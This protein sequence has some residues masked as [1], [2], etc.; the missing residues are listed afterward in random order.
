MPYLLGLTLVMCALLACPQRAASDDGR[1]TSA[2]GISSGVS[3]R[4]RQQWD[5]NAYEPSSEWSGPNYTLEGDG[6]G[7]GRRGREYRNKLIAAGVLTG[8]GGTFIA[9]GAI[10]VRNHSADPEPYSF[11]PIAGYTF[12]AVGSI[13]TLGGVIWM[14]VAGTELRTYKHKRSA[15]LDTN[16]RRVQWDPRKAGL[17]F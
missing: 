5:P 9:V 12:I 6:E 4:T 11:I 15:S 8:I 17:V 1:D 7:L 13:T 3:K 2:S 10:A 16:G 14:A